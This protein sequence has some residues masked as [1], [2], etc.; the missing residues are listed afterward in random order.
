MFDRIS[1]GGRLQDDARVAQVLIA[2]DEVHLL[3]LDLQAAAALD[4]PRL[5]TA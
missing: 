3:R 5:A 4:L 1:T 2:L